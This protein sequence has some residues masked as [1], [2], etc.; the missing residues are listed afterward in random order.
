MKQRRT[1]LA[2]GGGGARGLAHLGAIEELLAAGYEV[3]RIVG[4]SVG[5]LVG[6][7]FAFD[8]N[9]A[10]VQQRTC[11]YLRS[12]AFAK[13]QRI[14]LGAHP[15][16]AE[17]NGGRVLSGYHRFAKYVRAN[18]MLYRAV[19]SSSLLPGVLLEAVVNHLLPDADIADAAIPLS[20]VAVDLNTGQPVVFERG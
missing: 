1:T 7:Q 15:A 20:I 5:S 12:D 10:R 6:A 13:H 18:R 8:S 9:I 14:L 17:R 3:Q 19:S 16:P 2:L 11:E 4:V